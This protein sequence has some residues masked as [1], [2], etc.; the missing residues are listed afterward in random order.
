MMDPCVCVG[1]GGMVGVGGG[2]TSTWYRGE[3]SLGE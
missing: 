3:H 1:G 2:G